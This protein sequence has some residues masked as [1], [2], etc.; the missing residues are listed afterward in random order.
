M[1]VE[2]RLVY[3][4]GYTWY[5][6]DGISVKGFIYDTED[7]P[8]RE[9]GLVA[10]FRGADSAETLQD[11]LRQ[12]NGLFA[13]VIQTD[14]G[15]YCATDRTRTF[16]LYYSLDKGVLRI[17]DAVEHAAPGL[18]QMDTL[19]KEEF[20]YTGY[21]T[22]NSTLLKDVCQVQAGACL[23]GVDDQVQEYCYHFYVADKPLTGTFDALPDQL[24]GLFDK[25]GERLVKALAGRTAVVPLSG[26]YDS[27]LIAVLLKK[28]GYSKVI[29]FTYGIP[30]SP[31]VR[32]SARVAA[33]LGF[34]WHFI[35]YTPRL[36]GDFL[37]TPEF[38]A[39][40][41]FVVNGTSALFTQDYFAIRQLV[42]QKMIPEDAVIVPGHTGDFIAG[43]HLEAGLTEDNVA[44]RL[45]Q[46]HYVFRTGDK[47]SLLS[48]IHLPA[49]PAQPYE[50]FEHWNLKERQSKFIIN[51][52]RIYEFWGHEHL[53]PLWDKDLLLFFQNLPW[54]YKWGRK[55]FDQVVFR[56]FFEPYSVAFPKKRYPFVLQKI[57]GARNRMRRIFFSDPVN[58]KL[59]ARSFL[60]DRQLG[61]RW[62]NKEV[63]INRIQT[64]WYIA[65]LEDH[66]GG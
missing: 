1:K 58:F 65:W 51:S 48:R 41:P 33:E 59:I 28:Q 40:L 12:A 13:V 53:V 17:S 45:L 35:A 39:Y 24:A 50:Y 55:L 11:R 25:A 57:A 62:S 26:G 3:N 36:V 27:R 34:P 46:R 64:A 19:S 60:K 10:F 44:E 7:N 29:C 56:Y 31:D 30:S 6:S 18:L 61:L 22:G 38:K 9:A 20:L 8:L 14:A 63:N 66:L 52:N 16:P 43:G 32:M 15:V 54:E 2:V 47:R 42:T 37:H 4:Y 5:T 23:V 49:I 21:V